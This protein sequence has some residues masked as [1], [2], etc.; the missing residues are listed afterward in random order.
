MYTVLL[1]IHILVSIGLVVSVLLQSS[2]G[3]GLGGAFGGS[4]DTLFGGQTA[5]SFL[6]KATRTLGAAF[7]IISLLLAISNPSPQKSVKT[8]VGVEEEIQKQAETEQ[9]NTKP[10]EQTQIPT[11]F[12]KKTEKPENNPKGNK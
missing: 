5:S 11:G 2:K 6:K 4:S 1:T 3:G 12:E 7:M 10:L 8:G 9:E